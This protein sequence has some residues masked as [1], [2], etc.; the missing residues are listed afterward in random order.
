MSSKYLKLITIVLT[1]TI[2]FSLFPYSTPVRAASEIDPGKEIRLTVRGEPGTKVFLNDQPTNQT[3]PAGGSLELSVG[4]SE[5]G[6]S[7]TYKITLQ[8]PVGNM[9]EPE[10]VNLK[11]KACPRPKTITARKVLYSSGQN[12]KD[13]DYWGGKDVSSLGK[14]SIDIS[15]NKNGNVTPTN[16]NIPAPT[17][18]YVNTTHDE[19]QST[20]YGVAIRK[21]NA[22][23]L[24][25][26]YES[27]GGWGFCLKFWDCDT[28][29]EEK[30]EIN[31][32]HASLEI[33]RSNNLR[34]IDRVWN[35]KSDGRWEFSMN[36][37][38]AELGLN[39]DV[40]AQTVLYG[41][42]NFKHPSLGDIQI[43]YGKDK[44][45]SK[46]SNKVK[47]VSKVSAIKNA[48]KKDFGIDVKD[49]VSNWSE[50]GVRSVQDVLKELP[51]A[52]YNHERISSI[53]REGANGQALAQYNTQTYKIDV[54]DD[55][56]N[57]NNTFSRYGNIKGNALLKITLAHEIAHSYQSKDSKDNASRNN[58][59][60]SRISWVEDTS[61][62]YENWTLKANA[63]RTTINRTNRSI[64]VND[65]VTDY[66]SY[67][68]YEDW[69]ESV[70]VYIY[71]RNRFSEGPNNPTNPS[72][73]DGTPLKD[74]EKIIDQIF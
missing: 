2:V 5:C 49:G 63:R 11:A 9:S 10:I 19:K 45:R 14:F 43:D 52:L 21:Q 22:G 1:L 73:K 33:Q 12:G 25:I 30:K 56:F 58:N 60:F 48:I 38:N 39:D 66:A 54:F 16:S 51:A 65:F 59:N 35:D 7:Y 41:I 47:A 64:S 13:S 31:A 15:I 3:I 46:P 70:S 6:K 62:S 17:I 69:A 29:N 36:L 20:L 72:T 8:D 4:K 34:Y 53:S 57:K 28:W 44:N 68:T 32:E 24:V 23:E 42:Y 40:Q 27:D 74:K 50:D 55:A 71:L 67:A 37:Q 26:K 18:T 61:S